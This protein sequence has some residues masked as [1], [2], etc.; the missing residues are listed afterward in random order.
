MMGPLP[1]TLPRIAMGVLGLI[2]LT[3][4]MLV[5]QHFGM[6]RVLAFSSASGSTAEARDDR[7][8]QGTSVASLTRRPDALVMDC[9]L[10]KTLT[11]PYCLLIF[12]LSR[13]GVGVDLS[14][15][16]FITVDISYAGPSRP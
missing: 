4:S 10:R 2:I 15:F 11:Y 1:H 6:E 5:W 16:D 13:N 14:E 12:P 7:D 3:I 9:E 8:E